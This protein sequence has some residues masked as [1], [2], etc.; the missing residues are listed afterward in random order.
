M[1]IGVLILGHSGSG[2]STS[3]R[4]CTADR[5]GVVNVQGKPLPFRTELKTYNTDNYPDIINAL[6]QSTTPSI[7]IDDSQY[8]MSHEYMYRA[9]EAGYGKYSEIGQHF[10]QLLE[11]IRKL[12]DDRI[13]YMMHHIEL[14]DAGREKAK[15]VGKM[16]D[17]YIV[18]EGCFSIVL[19]A[20]ATVDGYF[21]RTK[22][23]G[24]DAVKTPLGMFDEEQID[25]DLLLVDNTI[26]QYYGKEIQ[27]EKTK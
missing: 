4:N 25:N 1:G 19:K 9:S 14:D 18:V 16:V 15:T 5:F 27:N 22:T 10:F 3:M 24:A 26:R 21:F 20:I 17:N 6:R 11:A 8:L 12:P 7:V 13:V 2:K 23:N